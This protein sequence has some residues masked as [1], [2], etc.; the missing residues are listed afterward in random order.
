MPSLRNIARDTVVDFGAL[1]SHESSWF[2]SPVPRLFRHGVQPL[3][4]GFRS[5]RVAVGIVT[6]ARR[7]RRPAVCSVGALALVKFFAMR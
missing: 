5:A 4:S 1:L 2:F 3:P 6:L 7:C